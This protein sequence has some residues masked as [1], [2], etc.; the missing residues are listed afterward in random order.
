LHNCGRSPPGTIWPCT[1]SVPP[2]APLTRRPARE[3]S[4]SDDLADR[5]A[6]PPSGCANFATPRRDSRPEP[7]APTARARRSS[8][9]RA[10]LVSSRWSTRRSPGDLGSNG[11]HLHSGRRRAGRANEQQR[12]T[13]SDLRQWQPHRMGEGHRN[14]PHGHSVATSATRSRTPSI[15]ALPTTPGRRSCR[16]CGRTSIFHTSCSRRRAERERAGHSSAHD[17]VP[18]GQQAARRLVSDEF[19]HSPIARVGRLTSD[20][21][22]VRR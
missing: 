8:Y 20:L 12:L 1:P 21:S 13:V 18:R 11:A 15:A 5:R 17:A 22:R 6:L 14:S 4:P 7:P 9:G 16:R 10:R 19:R 3:P 2:G